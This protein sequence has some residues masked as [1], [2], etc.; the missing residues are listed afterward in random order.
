MNNIIRKIKRLIKNPRYLFWVFAK[1]GFFNWMDDEQYIKLMYSALLG[2][3]LNLDNPVTFNEKLQWIK[4]YNHRNIYTKMVDKYLAKDFIKEVIGEKYVVPTYAVW[5]NTDDINI[6]QLPNSF[7]LKCNHDSKGLVICKDKNYF[8]VERA[9]KKLKKCLKR[10]FFYLAREW[11]YKNVK[12]VIIAEQYLNDGTDCLTDY[13][14]FC[15]NG[16]PKVMYISQ[17]YGDSPHTDF[18]DMD[19]N[20]LNLHMADPNSKEPINKP[21]CFEEMQGLARKLSKGIPHL[22]VDFYFVN[23]NIYV[24]ELTFFHNC[25]FQ[26]I[27]PKEWAKIMGDWIELP[28]KE[29]ED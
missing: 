15:F 27:Y 2:E 21:S 13:K 23:G 11:P 5:N 4:L 16:E 24:G 1:R 26:K 22:R 12:P 6:S 17:D 10:N 28:P 20:H 14:F 9:K 25:G 7:V 18:F 29:I 3:K 8:D 19:F